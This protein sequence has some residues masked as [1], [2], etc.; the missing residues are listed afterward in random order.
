MNSDGIRFLRSLQR[1]QRVVTG[2]E[3]DRAIAAGKAELT[4]A[5]ARPVRCAIKGCRRLCGTGQARRLWIDGHKRGFACQSCQWDQTLRQ[6]AHRGQGK[7]E[8]WPQQR[9]ADIG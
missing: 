7:G 8:T 2:E 9:P 1:R 3:L 5:N 6:E 4:R